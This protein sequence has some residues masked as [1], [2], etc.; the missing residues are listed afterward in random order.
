V[1]VVVPPEDGVDV[2]LDDAGVED[3]LDG[4]M[5]TGVVVASAVVVDVVE[6]ASVDVEAAAALATPVVGTV[7]GGAPEVSARGEELP[8]HAATPTAARMPR[9]S[10]AD[11]AIER[12]IS[13]RYERTLR[14]QGLHTPATVGAVVEVLLGKLVT[15]VA[16]TEVLDRPRKLRGCRCERE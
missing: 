15:P 4:V 14:T 7:S 11:V 2:V 16:K 3:E 8:P 10:A 13:L 12:R 6:P 5:D 1:D 9:S